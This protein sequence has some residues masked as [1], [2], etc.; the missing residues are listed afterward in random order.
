MIRY[1]AQR[2]LHA[3]PV[4]F[5]V[6]LITF[7]LTYLLPADPA[8]MYAGPNATI[9]TVNSIRHQ[10]GLDRPFYE[11]YLFYIGRVLVGDLGFSYKLQMPVGDAILARF[12]Y[13]LQ[14]TAGGIFFELLLGLPIGLISAL[15]QGTWVDRVAMLFVFFALAA[16]PFWLGLM[17]L[18]FA[19]FKAG[20]FPIGG[21]G[22]I[23]HL[24]LPA[25]AAGMGGAAW[26]AR[27]M[28]SS[29]LDVIRADYVRTA[30][31]KGLR[32]SSVVMRHILR[33]AILPIITLVGLDIPWF[34]SGVVL[35]EAVFAWPGLGKL[36][37]DAV[38]NVDVPLI[39]GTVL[40]TA[41]IV[42]LSNIVTD[43]LYAFVDPRIRYGD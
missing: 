23:W 10:L 26:Y 4:L 27:L 33:N 36:A 1:I 40:F 24:F 41:L 19:A 16:P 25:L 5:G 29:A 2:L 18:Y 17:L 31:A 9:A 7:M 35:I 15:R 13:T 20:L 38:R 14:L 34:L 22:T 21:T 42:V 8:R 11:Q 28:R 12:P 30:R 43:L 37:V 3:I 32:E 6:S 39:L